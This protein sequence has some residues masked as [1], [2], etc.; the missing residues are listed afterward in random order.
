METSLSSFSNAIASHYCRKGHL[1]PT[2]D[3][4]DSMIDE[5]CVT[6]DQSSTPNDSVPNNFFLRNYQFITHFLIRP[7]L[8][9]H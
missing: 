2:V 7:I 6:Q 9:A 4:K 1:A 5:V 3:N 8:N